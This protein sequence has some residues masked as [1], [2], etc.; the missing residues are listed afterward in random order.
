MPELPEVETVR[1]ELEPWLAGRVIRSAERVQAPPGPKYEALER[2]GGQRI[3]AVRRRGKFLLLPLSGGDELVIH[4]GMTGRICRDDPET[5]VRVRL[6]LSGRSGKQL[7]FQDVRRFGRFLVV[8]A[9]D[10]ARLPT[11]AALGPEPLEATFSGDVLHAALAKSRTPI[12]AALLSQRPVAGVG[13]IYADEAL[14]QAGIDPR[15][16]AN[17]VSRAKAHLLRDAIVSLLEAAIALRGTTFSDYRTVSGEEGGFV[18]RLTTYGRAGAPCARC[19]AA[20][21][22][23]VLAQRGTTF[24]PRCQR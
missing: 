23:V 13:N 8:P 14:W 7:F 4:L 15:R 20:L 16:A 17:R 9:G 10:Y 1:R 12:K 11:L 5:H 2:A 19:Q 6:S 3:E 21:V 22:R 24:C 18:S